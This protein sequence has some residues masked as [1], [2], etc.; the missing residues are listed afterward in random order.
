MAKV[1]AAAQ[2]FARGEEGAALVEYA[3]ALALLTVLSISAVTALASKI[4]AFLN[5]ASTTI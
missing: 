2:S 4:V 5:A 3:L 1:L